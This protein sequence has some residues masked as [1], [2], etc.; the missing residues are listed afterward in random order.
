MLLSTKLVNIRNILAEHDDTNTTCSHFQEHL[1]NN[2]QLLCYGMLFTDIFT[3]K[4]LYEVVNWSDSLCTRE[5]Y[6]L[7]AF[8]MKSGQNEVFSKYV[9][10][11]VLECNSK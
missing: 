11:D 1:N 3:I 9:C 7:L 4:I 5:S 2:G 6:I 10:T 8:E